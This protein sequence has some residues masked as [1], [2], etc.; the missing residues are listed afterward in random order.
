MRVHPGAVYL[1]Q[2]E[3]FLVK[4]FN[5]GLR[6]AIVSP[7]TGDFYTHPRELND[8]QIVRSLRHRVLRTTDT[9]WGRVRVRSQVIGYRRL[10]QFSKEVL[11][12]VPLEMPVAGCRDG[13]RV[14]GSA[15]R[16]ATASWR[17]AGWTFWAVS[18]PPSMRRSAFCPCSPCATGGTSAA[19]DR[20]TPTRTQR[21]LHLRRLSGRRRHRR[22]RV[23]AAAGAVGRDVRRSAAARAP[24]VPRAVCK[25]R[26]AAIST[27]RWTRRRL[28]TFCG[29]CW[30]SDKSKGSN[31]HDGGW[32]SFI[33][34]DKKQDRP[35]V[36]W[37]LMSR[38]RVRPALCR[39][40][41][42]DAGA[43]PG[44]HAAE[45]HP[46]AADAQPDRLRTRCRRG[47]SCA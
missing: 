23:R 2:G 3:A 17:A 14:V 34:Y 33:R 41:H 8:V 7:T 25:V 16:S 42:A 11:E 15:R 29:D 39:Q 10:R 18:T 9:Y 44:D 35:Q 43:H 38:G 20:A 21:N 12:D 6:H 4:E 45:S 27:A 19:L 26:N 46:A 30:A 28:D 47:M 37:A 24:T 22:E 36:S 1:H 31:M 13:G 5:S 40:N 32:W